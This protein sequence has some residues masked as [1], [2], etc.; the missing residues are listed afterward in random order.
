MLPSETFPQILQQYQLDILLTGTGSL[1]IT[2]Q[3]APLYC[4]EYGITCISFL[5]GW[6][7][8]NV[9]ERYQHVPDYI[10]TGHESFSKDIKRQVS[11]PNDQ[12]L[13]LGNPF[14][15]QYE[16]EFMRYRKEFILTNATIAYVS[17]PAGSDTLNE[18]S[19]RSKEVF[20]ELMELKQSGL[21]SKIVICPHP[22][23]TTKWFQSL[24]SEYDDI[25]IAT[26]KTIDV[27]KFIA[28]M[29]VNLQSTIHYESQLLGIPSIRYAT[30]DDFCKRMRHY[31]HE[32]PP[33]SFGATSR[34]TQFIK[35]FEHHINYKT[36]KESL[37]V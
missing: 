27:L 35:D 7:S 6:F 29:C 11:I 30:K 36:N 17:E 14:F 4:K 10:I 25:W 23:E 24:I 20:L 26:E 22:R 21:F 15:D 18:P 33:I 8:G 5:D 32:I 28:D 19:S 34:V 13:S 9:V 12:V 3:L 16:H 37:S 31:Q 1:H 2:E